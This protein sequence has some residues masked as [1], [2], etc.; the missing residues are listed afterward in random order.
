MQWGARGEEEEKREQGW[1]WREGGKGMSWHVAPMC[2]WDFSGGVGVGE[3][4]IC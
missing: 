4:T 1:K 2:G 3:E